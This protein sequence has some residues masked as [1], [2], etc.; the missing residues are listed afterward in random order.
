[1]WPFGRQSATKSRQPDRQSSTGNVVSE[2]SSGPMRTDAVVNNSGGHH[3]HSSAEK[4]A[5]FISYR[6]SSAFVVDHIHEKLTSRFEA[7]SIFLDRSDIEPGAR[8]PDKI[9][10]AVTR[11]SVVLV[12]IGK[13]W[14]AA[15][16]QRTYRRRLDMPDDWV[17]QELEL[18]L[19]GEGAVIPVLIEGAEMPT[20]EQLPESLAALVERHA[21][22]LSRE[23][24][25]EDVERL[26]KEITIRLGT[27][28]AERLLKDDGNRFPKP[29]AYK[30]AALDQ[31]QLQEML[32]ELPQW[33]LVESILDDDPRF[34]A[35][36]KRIEIRR[37]FRFESFMDAI[38]FMRV[39]AEQIDAFGHHPRWEN[40]FRT[41]SVSY[42]TWDSGHRPSDRDSKCAHMLERVYQ[43][44]LAKRK[45]PRKG[46]A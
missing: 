29:A 16:D 17:R 2:A 1:M 30:P 20:A 41:V 12:I 6:R 4:T 35:G 21:I 14:I 34:G 28:R 45:H 11:A 3:A 27:E 8:F 13:D 38:E 23:H 40:V 31:S 42:S 18:A 32:H 24:F 36:N 37:D 19:R 44:F 15:Q 33:R 22:V 25:R 46:S 5:I 7:S 26:V 10:T 9:R 39:A 43:Q